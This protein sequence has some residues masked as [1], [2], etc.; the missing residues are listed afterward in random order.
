MTRHTILIADDDAN[1]RTLLSILLRAEGYE[2]IAVDNGFDLVQQAQALMPDL[3]L[4]DLMM[5]QLDG[6][7]AIRQLRSDTRTAHLPMIVLTARAATDDVVS[8]F[9]SGADDYVAKPYNAVELLA[10]IRRQLHRAAQRPVRS[11]LTGLAGNVLITEEIRYRLQGER[12]FALLHIDLNNF[13][14]FNDTYGFARGDRVIRLLAE[15][16]LECAVPDPPERDFVGHIGGDDFALVTL[17]ER[18]ELVCTRTIGSFDSRIGELYDP[19][20]RLR[21]YLEGTDRYGT[22]RRFP[23]TSIAIGGVTSRVRRF[24]SPDEM[25]QAATAM[26]EQAKNGGGSTHL[27]ADSPV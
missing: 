17:P 19:D 27:I 22:A 12:H 2:V 10:R 11:P 1:I 6:Y 20:D 24:I 14:A 25:G 3:L 5:P 16:L 4:I 8:G 21:G 9:E 18:I 23:I 26:K 7:E 13:K 15:I